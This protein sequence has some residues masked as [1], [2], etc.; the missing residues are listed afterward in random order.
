MRNVYFALNHWKKHIRQFESSNVVCTAFLCASETVPLA[1]IIL[2]SLS[3]LILKKTQCTILKQYTA[4][5]F[6]L[7]DM[8]ME[9]IA[10]LIITHRQTIGRDM[11]TIPLVLC[12]TL[13]GK[14]NSYSK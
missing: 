2:N 8:F 7:V 12:Y 14:K 11:K 5:G 4:H 13:P 6:L 10:W 3:M 9:V 1:K